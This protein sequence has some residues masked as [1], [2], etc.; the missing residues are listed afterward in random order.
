V[1]ADSDLYKKGVVCPNEAEMRAYYVL[2]D[3]SSPTPPY[4]DVR[5]DIYSTPEMQFAIKVCLMRA[6]VL[7]LSGPRG[8][9]FGVVYQVWEAVK[10]D[11]W[12]RFFKAVRE[13][14]YLQSCVLHL[15]FNSIRQ[16]ALQIMNKAF[17]YDLLCM[18]LAQACS[19]AHVCRISFAGVRTLSPT[20]PRPWRSRTMRRP[21]R[22]AASTA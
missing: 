15:Y 16:R 2:L 17:K 13:A 4:Y 20:L 7:S 14:S 22:C 6:I 10:A 11:D 21:R 5:P 12:Y 1:N 9:N 18:W 3:L 8:F 19:V